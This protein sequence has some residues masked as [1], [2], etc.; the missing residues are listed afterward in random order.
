M[1]TCCA[2]FKWSLERDLGEARGFD[3]ALG[4]CANCGRPWIS[5]FVPASQVINYEPV[6]PKDLERMR[7]LP[8]GRD[9][10]GFMTSWAR[11]NL[12]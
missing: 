11:E 6:G 9:L 2:S 1:S 4:S 7:A 12:G 3:F 5:V 10:A 8:G